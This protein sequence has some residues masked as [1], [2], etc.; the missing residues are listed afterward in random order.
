MGE[1]VNIQIRKKIG[2]NLKNLIEEKT[3]KSSLRNID[4]KTSKDHSWLGKVFRGEQNITVDS[5]SEILKEYKIQP[6]EVFDFTIRFP[7]EEE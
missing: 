2:E 5:L 1:P 3:G 4:A 7:K 6:K